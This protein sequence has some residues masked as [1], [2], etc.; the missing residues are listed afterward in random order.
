MLG[1]TSIPLA[2]E[3][4]GNWGSEARQ[5]FARLASRLSFS[6]PEPKSII[7]MGLYGK[8]NTTPVRCNTR[9]LLARSIDRYVP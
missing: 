8:M 6:L 3:C 5:T 4:Y 1:W 7:L 9:A 2:V